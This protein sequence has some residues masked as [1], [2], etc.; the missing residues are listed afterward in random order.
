MSEAL[1]GSIPAHLAGKFGDKI[2][3]S[4]IV[5]GELTRHGRRRRHRRRRQLSC[6]TIRPAS[7]SR[8]STSRA[9]TIHRASKRFDVVYHLLSPKKNL[10]IRV[11]GADGRGRAGAL[12]HRRLSGRPTGTSARPTTSTACCSPA[13]RT[14]AACSPT[15]V[16]TAIRC[17]R[18]FRS[19]ASSRCVTTTRSSAWS[20]SRSS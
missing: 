15:T 9:R 12:D 8:S 4:E 11:K 6:A 14:C 18:T 7:S 10:R 5:Y 20:T 3:K 13:I 17:A 19:P 16:L 2:A 1:P